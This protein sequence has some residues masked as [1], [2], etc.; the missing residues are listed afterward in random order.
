MSIEGGSDVTV[1]GAIEGTTSLEEGAVLV[2]AAG[3]KLAGSL[4]NRGLV[5]L[6]GTFGGSESGAGELR[7]EGGRIKQPV[8]RD[9]ISHYEW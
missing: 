4:T 5:I 1:T 2:I 9:G 3:A 8:I 6:R 7:L